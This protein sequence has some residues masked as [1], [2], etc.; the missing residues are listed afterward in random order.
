MPWRVEGCQVL[1]T[2]T[3]RFT[4]NQGLYLGELPAGTSAR[5]QTL[6]DTL[7]RGRHSGTGDAV[8]PVVGMGKIRGMAL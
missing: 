4:V 7:A 3:V 1:P 5:V 6:G 2:G 8:H